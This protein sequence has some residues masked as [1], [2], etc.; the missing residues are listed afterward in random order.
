MP[1]ASLL[2]V[3]PCVSHAYIRLV[4][5]GKPVKL[6]GVEIKPVTCSTRTST[7]FA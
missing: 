4:D 3:N 5:F 1:W 2:R 6:A 7:A